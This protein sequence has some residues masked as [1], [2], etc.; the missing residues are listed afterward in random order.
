MGKA[1]ER[2]PNSGEVP[3]HLLLVARGLH[4]REVQAIDLRI[5][6]YADA[7]LGYLSK[8]LP[9]GNSIDFVGV[10]STSAEQV[11]LVCVVVGDVGPVEALLQTYRIGNMSILKEEPAYKTVLL[12][13]DRTLFESVLSV[14]SN[15]TEVG[16]VVEDNKNRLRKV[17]SGFG[18]WS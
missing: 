4:E 17:L 9:A 2:V 15:L 11:R 6:Y 16:K 12:S 18:A 1:N 13:V 3:D 10:K 7:M 5:K 8:Q 14:P